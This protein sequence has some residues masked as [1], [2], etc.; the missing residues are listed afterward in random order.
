MKMRET[1][2]EQDKE[3]V[4]NHKVFINPER[5]SPPDIDM[6]F[7][8][9]RRQDVIDYIKDKYGS[10]KV[11]N[12]ITFGTLAARNVIRDV[13]RVLESNTQMI[14]ALA[15]SV[16]AEPKM[17]LEKAMS[18]SPDFS[19]LYNEDEEAKKVVDIASK[20]EGL[21]RQKSQHACGIIVS[22]MAIKDTVPEVLIEDKETKTK[23]RVAGFNMVELEELGLLKMDFLGLRNMSILHYSCDS[24]ND[25]FFS[26][27]EE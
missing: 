4:V 27:E 25:R 1:S 15:K 19:K 23:N 2:R 8:D 14:D 12:I 20:L 24:I 11:S 17:T 5:I 16:P 10:E 9:S 18:V 3:L 7:E 22:N 26:D 21:S 13:G 6:D